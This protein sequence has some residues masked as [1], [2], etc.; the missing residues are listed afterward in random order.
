MASGSSSSSS[1][2]AT[3]RVGGGDGS[4][5]LF[6]DVVWANLPTAL[7]LSSI[8]DVIISPN[9][10]VETSSDWSAFWLEPPKTGFNQSRT[11][12]IGR[13]FC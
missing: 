3:L 4:L 8:S 2:L 10:V 9:V 6:F 1:T 13:R 11:P 7:S 12:V 5:A